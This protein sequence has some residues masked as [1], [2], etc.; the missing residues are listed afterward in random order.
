MT[1]SVTAA[2]PVRRPTIARSASTIALVLI[3]TC[4][5]MVILD[6]TIVTIALPDIRK[7]LHF[8]ST[9]LSWVQN[10]YSLTFGGLL[11]LARAPA[12]FSAAAGSS[13]SASS[14]SP[15]RRC[16]RPRAS[17]LSGCSPPGPRRASAPRSP[18]RPP[19]RC[20]PRASP[21]ARRGCVRSP[22]QRCHLR[23]RERRTR[24]RRCAHR[25]GVLALVADHQRPIG[26]VLVLLARATCR[27]ERQPGRFDLAGA[28]T[29]TV[30]WPHSC[31]ASCGRRLTAGPI[32]ARSSLRR[33]CHVAG[34]VRHGRTAGRAADHAVADVHQPRAQQLL[35]RSAAAR[36]RHVRHVLLHD[37]IPGRA[38][39][40]TARSRPASRSCPMT[41][42]LFAMVRT[43]PK[44]IARIGA[45][46]LMVVGVGL[47][48]VSMIG[49]RGSRR[50]PSTSRASSRRCSC[51]AW[52]WASPSSR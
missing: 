38:C 21:R 3:L 39:A 27:D 11:L 51:W 45:K 12:T 10:A 17:R 50:T 25:L 36:R 29:S 48:L 33:G 5:L 46:Q 19:W 9:S 24:P 23:R 18:L 1:S 26:I 13:S 6:A 41:V 52:V 49:C 30:A 47:A 28:I 40:T 31:T 42:A 20:S 8:S 35:R 32:R 2:P 15:S 43:V 37:A 14:C 4:Q 22:V 44:Y 34:A 7:T 16:S